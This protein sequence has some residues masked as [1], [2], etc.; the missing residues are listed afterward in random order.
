MRL[1]LAVINWTQLPLTAAF[2]PIQFHFNRYWLKII[3]LIDNPHTKTKQGKSQQKNR[4]KIQLF[5]FFLPFAYCGRK[6]FTPFSIIRE[7]NSTVPIP[8]PCLAGNYSTGSRDDQ[9]TSGCWQ[10]RAHPVL[11]ATLPC[12]DSLQNTLITLLLWGNSLPSQKLLQAPL[13]SFL[14]PQLRKKQKETTQFTS[15]SWHWI[16]RTRLSGYRLGGEGKS[17][18]PTLKITIF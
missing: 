13:S 2:S 1:D 15:F 3:D 8:L 11:C 5:F 16:T 17:G 12:I 4:L 10:K 7:L 18:Q 6:A 14:C 9:F